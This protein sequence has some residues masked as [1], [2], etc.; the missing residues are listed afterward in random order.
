LGKKSSSSPTLARK[1]KDK[2]RAKKWYRIIA[3]PMF[4]KAQIAETL[5]DEPEKI[6]N[7]VT[8]VTVQDLT[9][10]FSKMHIKLG[11]RIHRLQGLDAHTRFIGHSFTSDYVRRQTRRKRSKIDGVF[12]VETK[13]GYRIRIKPMAVTEKRIQ[14]TKQQLIRKNMGEVI[15]GAAK[16]KTLGEFIKMMLGGELASAVF[17]SCKPIYP[18]KRVEI[19]K[20]EIL[21]EPQE[22]V[23]AE[24][25]EALTEVEEAPEEEVAE[26]VPSKEEEKKVEE[27]KKEEPKPEEKKVEE[28]KKEEPKPEE[29][30]K[31]PKKKAKKAP[32]KEEPEEPS[33]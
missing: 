25:E 30:K 10:D 24:T 28:P 1:A 9:G 5:G 33:E 32:V 3:P 4:N 20:S 23:D 26:E 22:M 21:F 17:K 31:A 19:F 13:E 18:I 8:E 6:L 11:F 14:S 2:W 16:D 7:R 15:A 29:K 27:P 12:N